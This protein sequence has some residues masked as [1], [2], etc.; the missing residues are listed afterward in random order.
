MSIYTILDEWQ[1][2]ISYYDDCPEGLAACIAPQPR[3]FHAEL[4]IYQY[5]LEQSSDEIAAILLHEVCHIIT[6]E[7]A[8]VAVKPM[9]DEFINKTMIEDASE[10]ATSRIEVVVTN[11]LKGN[12]NGYKEAVSLLKEAFR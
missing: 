9:N 3:Y 6:H 8:E 2:D 5:L 10:K 11:L 1:I 12:N 4:S 7:Q